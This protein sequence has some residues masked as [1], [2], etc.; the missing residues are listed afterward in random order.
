MS[1]PNTSGIPGIRA[2]TL[3]LEKR[4]RKATGLKLPVTKTIAKAIV[5]GSVGN[6]LHL[7]Q[8]GTRAKAVEAIT[9][10][11]CEMCGDEHLD[12]IIIRGPKGVFKVT[13]W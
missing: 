6:L 2:R 3:A 13:S 5:T 11:M 9:Y 7:A 1:Q 12:P 10:S 8:E 4:I